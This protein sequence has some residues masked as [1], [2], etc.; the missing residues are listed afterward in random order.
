MKIQDPL[1]KID[2][3]SQKGKR[4]SHSILSNFIYVNAV[5]NGGSIV[6]HKNK[7]TANE[8]IDNSSNKFALFPKPAK[9]ELF[10]TNINGTAAYIITNSSG[11]KVQVGAVTQDYININNI[12]KIHKPLNII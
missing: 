7:I 4:I 10:I 2:S 6:F 11:S 12:I 1:R 8:A 9:N 3:I 5:P